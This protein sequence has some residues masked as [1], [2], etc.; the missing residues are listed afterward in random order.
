MPLQDLNLDKYLKYEVLGI[1]D[2]MY[3]IRKVIKYA[4]NIK[5]GIHYSVKETKRERELFR[6]FE[7]SFNSNDIVTYTLKRIASQVIEGVEPLIQKLY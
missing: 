3:S 2:E 7:M 5:G 1:S 4:A 6:M